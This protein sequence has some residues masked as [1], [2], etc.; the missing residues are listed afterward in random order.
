MCDCTGVHYVSIPVF[1]RPDAALEH[2]VLFAMAGPKEATQ[3]L[4]KYTKWMGRGTL[5]WHLHAVSEGMQ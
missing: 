2:R 4:E 3:Q 1:G 5:V